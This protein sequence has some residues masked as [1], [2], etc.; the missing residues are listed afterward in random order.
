MIKFLILFF[1]FILMANSFQENK[2]TDQMIIKSFNDYENL[3]NKKINISEIRENKF[4]MNAIYDLNFKTKKTKINIYN[5][6]KGEFSL[7][8]IEVPRYKEALKELSKTNDLYSAWFAISI[9]HDRLMLF[10]K[11]GKFSDR[12]LKNIVNTNYEN[13]LKTM[14]N[15]NICYGYLLSIEYYKYYNNN[16][17]KYIENLNSGYKKCYNSD[18]NWIKQ[19]IKSEYIQR[20]V[21]EKLHKGKNK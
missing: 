6:T 16:N 1:P 21:Y 2:I 14:T 19:R 11:E 8:N 15:N 20:K 10:D 17:K 13:F 5:S 7:V 3:T 9:I 12:E 4:L 18:I